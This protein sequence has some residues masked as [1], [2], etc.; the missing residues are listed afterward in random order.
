MRGVPGSGKSTLART[1]APPEAIC[2]ADDY[3]VGDDG[4][5]RWRADGLDQAHKSCA[6]KLR[7]RCAKGAPVVVVDNTNTRRDEVVSYAQIAE[8]ADYEVRVITLQPPTAVGKRQEYVLACVS[9][10]LHSVPYT[11]VTTMANRLLQ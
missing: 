5:Y 9:R 11:T 4:V 1:L 6:A 2:S 10:G 7:D 8:N 3:F